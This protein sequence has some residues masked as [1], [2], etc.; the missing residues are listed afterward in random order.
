MKTKEI[1]WEE[2]KIGDQFIDGSIVTYIAP[3]SYRKCFKIKLKEEEPIVVSDDHMMLA[4]IRDNNGNKVEFKKS[5]IISHII[6]SNTDNDWY[7][8]S[9]IF[10]AVR[11]NLNV[12]LND[13]EVEFIEE[14][15]EPLKVRCIETDTGHYLINGIYH[16][17]T[18][19]KLF[20]ALSDIEVKKDCG[21]DHSKGI[22]NCKIP[23]G[24]CSKCA[25]KDGINLK[26]GTL[27]GSQISTNLSEPLTQLSMREFHT[28]GK[29]L[30]DSKERNII[31]N[32]FDAYITS[33]IIAAA[34]EAKTTEDR[35]RIIYEGLKEQYSKNNIKMD[36][37]NI[38]IIAKK[39]TSYIN[40][41][42]TGKRYV[43]EGECCS[44]SSIGS[45]GNFQNPFK[46]AE[47]QSSYKTLTTPGRYEIR[48]DAAQEIIF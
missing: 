12:L 6:H 34:K 21:G 7:S 36:D 13:I 22:L 5:K 18:A 48:R 11:L 44:I 8:A 25:K 39:M 1:L 4:E 43:K 2:L 28:G 40:D 45:I 38:M 37:L 29:N 41:P 19:R 47:L 10:N 27:I 30:K 14:I 42:K 35:R 31:N 46:K 3:W 20:Y 15:E 17:N 9:D 24:I 16:H 32:T 26:P 23:G 33:P